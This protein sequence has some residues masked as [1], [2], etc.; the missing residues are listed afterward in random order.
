MAAGPILVDSSFYITM[1]RNGQDP[2]QA[3]TYAAVDRDLAVCGIVRC[4]VARGIRQP[5]ALKHFQSFWDVMI[6]VPTDNRL[7]A[8][9]EELAWQ[10]DRAGDV[11]PLTDIVIACC[12]MRIDATVLSLDHH[13]ES[14]PGLRYIERIAD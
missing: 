5:K 10:L 12:A 9:V 11:L 6:N 2:L 7:W 8:K 13:F 3:L 4:E 14:I 1:A